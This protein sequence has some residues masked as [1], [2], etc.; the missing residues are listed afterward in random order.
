MLKGRRYIVPTIGAAGLA[1]A[2]TACGTTEVVTVRQATPP[3]KTQASSPAVRQASLPAA[4]Q[5]L[6]IGD[7]TTLTGNTPGEKLAVTLAAVHDGF[8][9]GGFD[10]PD[11]GTRFVAAE[12]LLRNIGTTAYSDSPDNGAELIDSSD[13][14]IDTDI[15]ADGPYP[16]SS[17]VKIA[18]G[19]V[20]RVYVDFQLP[21]SES[22]KQ[23]QFTLDSGLADQ[24][25]QWD[26]T[27]GAVSAAG[28]PAPA[29]VA[30][31]QSSTAPVPA[32]PVTS[33]LHHVDQNIQANATT[34]DGFAKSIFVAYFN[35]FK[36]SGIGNY[37]L[38]VMSGATGKSYDVTCT[39]NGTTVNCSGAGHDFF[40][41]FPVWA[42]QV[43]APTGA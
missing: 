34:S 9:T 8:S 4:P 26:I 12:L 28:T 29:H 22:L 20:R 3:A 37:T 17:D 6:R 21:Q 11:P 10:T 40:V 32:A 25:G 16:T 1:L 19:D 24:T 41:T 42:I 7:T 14:Q 43:Y 38:S 31:P 15:V 2:L 35:E 18:T 30:A 27:S 23:F 36:N 13:N 33:G 39:T 5:V